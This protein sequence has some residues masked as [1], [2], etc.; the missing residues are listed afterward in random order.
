MRYGPAGGDLHIS[1]GHIADRSFIQVDDAGPGV[2][3]EERDRIFELFYRGAHARAV[4]GC[5]IGL[6]IVQAVARL[7][8]ADIHLDTS[9]LG[10]L[11]VRVTFPTL[12]EAA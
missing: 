5:G 9:S 3:A 8:R 2:V 11:S 4:D 12:A 6:S 7:H 10:G 1:T